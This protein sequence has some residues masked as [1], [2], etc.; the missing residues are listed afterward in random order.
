MDRQIAGSVGLQQVAKDKE[1]EQ[2]SQHTSIDD[3]AQ[4][5]QENISSE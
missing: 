3:M 5:I 1:I 4:S 2:L